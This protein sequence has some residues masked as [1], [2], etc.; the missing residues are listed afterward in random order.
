MVLD[1]PSNDLAQLEL[2]ALELHLPVGDAGDV[3]QVVEEA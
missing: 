2:L 3:E 1:R